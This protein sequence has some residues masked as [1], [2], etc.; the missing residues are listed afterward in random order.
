[1][2]PPAPPAAPM[3]RQFLRRHLPRPGR[4]SAG[5]WARWLPSWRASP[6]LFHLNRR[7]VSLACGAGVFCALLPVPGQTFAALLLALVL[8]CNLPLAVALVWLTNPLTLS[9]VFWLTFEF[10]RWLLGSPPVELR[11]SGD[12]NDLI[13]QGESVLLPLFAGSLTAGLV[14]GI[15]LGCAVHLWWR[16][17]VVRL[18]RER[19]RRRPR[20]TRSATPEP[21]APGPRATRDT[22]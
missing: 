15:A 22:A 17:E 7:S 10:G 1:M 14:L 13:H 3:P 11:L 4:H 6:Q 9:P 20:P 5:R 21:A 12:W 16:W 18:W 19:A 2:S 8:R